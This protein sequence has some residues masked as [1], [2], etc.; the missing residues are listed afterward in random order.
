MQI[1][2]NPE[3]GEVRRV[4]IDGIFWL[5]G[6]DVAMALGYK[7][8]VNAIKAHVDLEDKGTWQIATPSGI[9]DMTIINE[10]GVYSLIFSSKLPDAKKFKK[11]VTSEVL[12]SVRQTGS[13]ST[14][15]LTP[16][17]LIAAQAQVL[18]D[19]EQKMLAIQNQTQAIQSQQAELA[20]RVD[21]AIK[22]F[23]RPSEDHW[24]ADIDQAIKDMCEARN[25]SECATRGRMYREL[26][27]KCGCDINSRLTRLRKRKKKQGARHKDAMALN[28][29]DAIAADKQLRAAFE[30]VV[31]EWQ[32]RSVTLDGQQEIMRQDEFPLSES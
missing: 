28:K 21:T 5:V 31:R 4:E 3:F 22:V 14:Q 8:T 16:A 11:W 24:K 6:K 29:L 17:Q 12:P 1:F 30:G 19:M 10:S 9:Q 27:Q 32:A 23:S 18:V 25:L 13:Y 2:S 7:D 26:E 20:Q 15:Q